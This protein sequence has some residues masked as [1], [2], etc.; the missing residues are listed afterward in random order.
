MFIRCPGCGEKQLYDTR[1]QCELCG[2]VLRRCV[3][4]ANYK[5]VGHRCTA[6]NIELEPLEAEKPGPLAVS[7]LCSDYKPVALAA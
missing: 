7:A 4:C 6:K 1:R 2:H 5:A 3:D